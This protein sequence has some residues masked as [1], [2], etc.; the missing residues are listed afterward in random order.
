MQELA[1]KMSALL[2]S[3]DFRK[4]WDGFQG[5]AFAIYDENRVYLFRHPKCNGNAY[6][7]F[8]ADNRFISC[9]SISFEGVPT[10]IVDI[11]YFDNFEEIYSLIVHESFHAYQ[12]ELSESRFPDEA[13]GPSFPAD[14][15]FIQL[16]IQERQMLHDAVN[17]RSKGIRHQLINGFITLRDERIRLYPDIVDYENRVETIEGPAFFVEYQ[18][19][20]DVSHSK[21][22]RQAYADMLLDAEDSHLHIRKSCSSSGLFLCLLLEGL[23]SRWQEDFM[24]SELSLYHFFKTHYTDYT[25]VIIADG[26]NKEEITRIIQTIKRQKTEA[27]QSFAAQPGIWLTITGAMQAAGFDPMNIVIQDGQVLHKH[28][29]KIRIGSAEYFIKGPVLTRFDPG[30]KDITSLEVHVAQLPAGSEN[31][32]DIEGIGRFKGH[33]HYADDRSARILLQ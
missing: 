33:I 31:A 18:A 23:P 7:V 2:P 32:I 30:F 22:A 4:Y 19:L 21:T 27:F 20:Q 1:E 10:A 28:F 6:I 17:E 8:P 14:F 9:T 3:M 11:R 15:R 5:K 26:N 12:H 29:L 24:H 13:V 16:R 25:P